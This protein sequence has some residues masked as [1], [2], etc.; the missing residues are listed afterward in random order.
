LSR[1]S[2]HSTTDGGEATA[3]NRPL[4]KSEA[5]RAGDDWPE[6]SSVSPSVHYKCSSDLSVVAISPN[7]FELLGIEPDNLLGSAA[8][9]K[10]RLPLQDRRRLWTRLN[11]EPSSRLVTE[12][13]RLID[14]R[15][16]PVWVTHSFRKV[17]AGATGK[18]LGCMIPLPKEFQESGLSPRAVSQFIHK[19]G[20]H[21][22]LINLLI[23]SLRRNV[24]ALDE[25][26]S[27]Q[28]TVDR[29]AEL[30][31][32]FLHYSQGPSTVS[33]VDLGELL[34]SV[35]YLYAPRFAEKNVQFQDLIEGS[36]NEVVVSGDP[37]SLEL[38]FGA[39]LRNALDATSSGD[40]VTVSGT[41]EAAWLAAD[42]VAR[43]T[44]A[45]T[46][47][48]IDPQLLAKIGDP[49]YTTKPER[50][51]LGLSLA[52]RII[53]GHGG[54]LSVSSSVGRGTGV[55]IVLP[56]HVGASHLDP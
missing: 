49:F 25:I 52:L 18:I 32:T 50:D 9:W 2:K 22:Q 38:A 21:F 12:V 47:A 15:G 1:V 6:S 20:N 23:G 48:G 10:E 28:D 33:E 19:I 26:E 31:R 7:A 4:L 39:I 55:D 53:D 37:F 36:V 44:I 29:A 30:M 34:H 17:G 42:S 56:V 45:D 14:D 3:F 40:L 16:S 11:D 24:T 8:L 27:L 13:H 43:I 46:G 35:F 51:G 5:F 54:W 41:L